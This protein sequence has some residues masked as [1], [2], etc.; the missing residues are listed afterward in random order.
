MKTYIKKAYDKCVIILN[1]GHEYEFYARLD[2]RPVKIM[3]ALDTDAQEFAQMN[4]RK[5]IDNDDL[6]ELWDLIEEDDKPF[7]LNSG[8]TGHDKFKNLR[9]PDSN[10]RQFYSPSN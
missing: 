8:E 9:G 6:A 2:R 5:F 1:N 4:N 3:L 10:V 7:G